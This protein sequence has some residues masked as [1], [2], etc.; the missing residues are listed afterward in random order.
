MQGIQGGGGILGG[1]GDFQMPALPPEIGQ[2][3]EASKYFFPRY[4]QIIKQDPGIVGLEQKQEFY[5]EA[6]D[7]GGQL[8][9]QQAIEPGQM[10]AF[11][12]DPSQFSLEGIRGNLGSRAEAIA[13][14]KLKVSGPEFD[15]QQ[16]QKTAD[17]LRVKQS[18]TYKQMQGGG[19]GGDGG[20][21]NVPGEFLNRTEKEIMRDK[22]GVYVTTPEAQSWNDKPTP[23]ITNRGLRVMQIA[24]DIAAKSKNRQPLSIINEAKAREKKEFV[25][26][27][28]ATEDV[29]QG[30]DRAANQVLSSA[31]ASTP[32]PQQRAATV[33]T[34]R[35]PSAKASGDKDPAT[36]NKIRV[37]RQKG[38]EAGRI[39][40]ALIEDG[41]NPAEYGY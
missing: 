8:V 25:E 32:T 40:Q 26:Q 11:A 2:S 34:G 16:A 31:P 14:G 7:R 27:Q 23:Q 24:E 28:K 39:R 5:K 15:R 38:V 19:G 36:E 29:I 10:E 30:A 6:L 13:R 3:P 17:R 33:Q 41:I 4:Q 1:G 18:P 9:G 20:S 21:F 12:R 37:L 35:S 22:S